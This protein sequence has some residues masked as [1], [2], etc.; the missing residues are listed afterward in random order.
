MP[1]KRRIP[2]SVRPKIAPQGFA[3]W[4]VLR[5]IAEALQT[6]SKI[7]GGALS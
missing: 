6:Q 4:R 5:E 7:S 3:I 2:K 1:A